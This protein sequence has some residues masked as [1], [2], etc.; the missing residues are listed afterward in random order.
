M[1]WGLFITFCLH[2]IFRENYKI[3]S[4]KYG[5]NKVKYRAEIDGL[6]ALAIIPVIFFHAGCSLFSGGY[7]GVDVF[8]VISGYL[9]TTILVSDLDAGNFSVVRFYERRA[10]RILPALFFVVLCSIPFAWALLT[11]SGLVDFSKSVTAVS[12][13]YSNIFFSSEGGYFSTA[14]DLKPLL[15]TWSL[16]VEEQYYLLFPMFLLFFWK[17][18]KKYVL[19]AVIVVGIVSLTLAQL[20]TTSKPVANFFLLQ[21]R[22]WELAFGSIAA[23]CLLENKFRLV[24]VTHK[25][26]YA[27]LGFVAIMAS[28]FFYDNGTPFPSLYGLLPTVGAVLIILFADE[29]THI[30][31]ILG[32]K[33]LT[34]VGLISYSAYLWHQPIFAFARS[35]VQI[36]GGMPNIVLIPFVLLIAVFSWKYIESPFRNPNLIG[37]KFIFYGAVLVG[38]FFALLGFYISN[39][40]SRI[41]NESY[42]AKQ[43]VASPAIYVS[44]MNERT[45]IKSRIEIEKISPKILVLG[46]S[47]IMQISSKTAG[48]ELLNLAVSGSSVEDDIA[49]W[50]LASEKF[51]P[52]VVL[53]GADP[54]LLNAKS[55]Q[56]RWRTLESDYY[57]GLSDIGIQQQSVPIIQFSNENYNNGF[58][59]DLYQYL[60]ISMISANNDSPELMDKIRKDGSRVY[61]LKYANRTNAEVDREA[62][63][64]ASYSMS[65]YEYSVSAEE[66]FKKL[67]K[68]IQKKHKVILVLSPYHPKLYNYMVTQDKKFLEIENKFK[69]LGVSLDVPVLGSYNPAV[70][71]C[72]DNEFYD[73]MHPKDSCMDKVMFF[74]K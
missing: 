49:I 74:I 68:A 53:I 54:W 66:R 4:I 51:Q 19:L 14:A 72:S 67:I 26:L 11:P 56:D 28:V 13:F 43:L 8:F 62:I 69:E 47:R 61:N 25:Q 2:L 29:D 38:G 6:R 18:G 1:Q 64:Y 36:F 63:S 42:I 39:E 16:A 41:S 73:G 59:A 17:I 9:I 24:K 27:S 52:D 22:A 34:S 7:A 55:G 32:S 23:L 12:L 5:G 60:N 37:A 31:K 44:N 33:A 45:F 70:I 15:H 10:R 35:G 46:S 48:R 3:V 57:L 21:S 71:G 50:K 65:P 40:L 20:G 30:G 58:L